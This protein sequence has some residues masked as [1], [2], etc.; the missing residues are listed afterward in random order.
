MRPALPG[1]RADRRAARRRRAADIRGLL[2]AGW[3]G[4]AGSRVA[5][6]DRPVGG[7]AGIPVVVLV[8]SP[9]AVP[10]GIPAVVLAG[11][12]V[13]GPVGSRVVV[14]VGSRGV[15]PAGTPAVVPAGSRVVV[16]AGNRAAVPAGTPAAPA[17][18]W[19]AAGRPGTAARLSRNR[20]TDSWPATAGWSGWGRSSRARWRHS[21]RFRAGRTEPLRLAVRP[22]AASLREVV[23]TRSDL[24]VGDESAACG[25]PRTAHCR[26]VAPATG[27]S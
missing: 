16:P 12:R 2:V 15:V 4:P 27:H 22:K 8:G 1:I 7:P 14:L 6:R 19:S 10:A 17:G 23:G 13:V 5:P 9:A 25:N 3:R 24:L 20:S 18:R 26:Q 21:R 11:N